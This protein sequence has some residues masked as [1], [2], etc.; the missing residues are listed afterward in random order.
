MRFCDGF[1]ILELYIY[2]RA[3]ANPLVCVLSEIAAISDYSH[4]YAKAPVCVGMR[5]PGPV[6]LSETAAT[7]GYL[8][9]MLQQRHLEREDWAWLLVL[10][11]GQEGLSLP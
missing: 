9:D 11:G 7:L 4:T 3:A 2:S 8:R 10:H 5:I 1:G 6:A